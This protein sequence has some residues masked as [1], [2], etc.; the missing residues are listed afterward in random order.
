MCINRD[1]IL[2]SNNFK[3][4]PSYWPRPLF[5]TNL[6]DSLDFIFEFIELKDRANIYKQPSVIGIN[7]KK[8]FTWGLVKELSLGFSSPVSKKFNCNGE[9]VCIF[10]VT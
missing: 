1:K 9:S 5:K 10:E 8:K 4:I 7:K 3:K 6:S 2:F